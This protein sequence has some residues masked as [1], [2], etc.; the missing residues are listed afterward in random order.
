VDLHQLAA[1][2]S[3]ADL[4]FAR[5]A[6]SGPSAP[7][8]GVKQMHHE[9]A[10]II[11]ITREEVEAQDISSTLAALGSLIK[12]PQ[13]ASNSFER[14]DIAFHGYN[15][16]TEELFEIEEVRTFVQALDEQFP[17]WLYFLNKSGA[18][19]QC[20][21]YCFLPPF[22]TDEGKQRYFPERLNDLL[23]RRWFPAMNQ[24]CE[25]T[26][27]TEEQI[28]SLSDRSVNYLLSGPMEA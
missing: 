15:D 16:T 24:I 11:V 17:Y 8:L 1:L 25:W 7:T 6:G 10:P 23:I 13:P 21:A 22:L 9:L 12:S 18:G 27:F 20:I 4:R 28:E 26:E 14:I 5:P 2:R 3:A 19:L